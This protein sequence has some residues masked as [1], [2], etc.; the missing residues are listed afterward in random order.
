MAEEC[1]PQQLQTATLAG[2]LD[3]GMYA[4]PLTIHT[5]SYQSMG[6]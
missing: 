6:I 5:D 2:I 4:G 3:P 1:L